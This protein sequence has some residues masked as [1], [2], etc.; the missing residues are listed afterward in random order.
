MRAAEVGGWRG[1]EWVENERAGRGGGDQVREP[2]VHGL[3]L[4]L[5]GNWF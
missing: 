4:R 3:L 1:G 5:V 2:D